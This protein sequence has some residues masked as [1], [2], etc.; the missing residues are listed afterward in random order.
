MV[1]ENRVAQAV[2]G[3]MRW[4]N[5]A[6]VRRQVWALEGARLSAAELSR[7]WSRTAQ[8]STNAMLSRVCFVGKAK[9]GKAKPGKHLPLT[10]FPRSMD[11]QPHPPLRISTTSS[12]A[13]CASEARA[14][15]DQFVAEYDSRTQGE[16]AVGAQLRKVCAALH[17]EAQHPE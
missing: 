17:A 4:A 1:I 8:T 12:N 5:R 11:A 2:L 9:L 13:T 3:L 10:S 16:S 14:I 6:D 7:E 15:L